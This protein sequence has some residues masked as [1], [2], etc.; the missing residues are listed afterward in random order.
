M[1]FSDNGIYTQK[2]DSELRMNRTYEI[3]PSIE[4]INVLLK[5]KVNWEMDY[6]F[7]EN[8]LH[9]TS[10]LYGKKSEFFLERVKK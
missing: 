3:K 10:T 2:I 6:E 1:K 5:D 8:Q 4:K 7:V 9:L